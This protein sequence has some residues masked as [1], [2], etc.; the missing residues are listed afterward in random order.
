MRIKC[1]F[2]LFLN[3]K[4]SMDKWINVNKIIINKLYK[5]KIEGKNNRNIEM[6][7]IEICKIKTPTFEFL[8][9]A[10]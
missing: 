5:F 6:N 2:A 1:F 10:I 3:F 9:R 4:V 8:Y 7:I